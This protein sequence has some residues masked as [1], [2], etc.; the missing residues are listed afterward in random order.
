MSSFESL[1][2]EQSVFNTFIKSSR[3]YNPYRFIV[4]SRYIRTNYYLPYTNFESLH[5]RGRT[6]SKEM[7][8]FESLNFRGRTKS[9]KYHIFE[10]EVKTFQGSFS[11]E[12]IKSRLAS[13]L[14]QKS[15]SNRLSSS[16]QKPKSNRLS[17]STQ[18]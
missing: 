5:F 3:V 9:R 13:G 1:L 17:S 6:K 18:K 2:F 16:T 15:K 12:N 11:K 8:S 10:L 7:S 14:K 4:I